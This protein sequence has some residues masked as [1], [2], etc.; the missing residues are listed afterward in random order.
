MTADRKRGVTLMDMNEII[1]SMIFGEEPENL[2]NEKMDI[3]A[4]EKTEKFME[5]TGMIENPV[6]VAS[7]ILDVE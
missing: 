3:E 4:M 2:L 5:D 6:D 1:K 7:L